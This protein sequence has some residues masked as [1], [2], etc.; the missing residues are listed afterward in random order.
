MRAFCSGRP[1]RGRPSFAWRRFARPCWRNRPARRSI[2][3]APKQATF[4]LE[5]QLLA[6]AALPGYIRLQILSFERLADFVLRTTGASPAGRSS[7]RTGGSM[8]LRALLARR[9]KELRIFHASAGLAGFA[10][11]LSLQLRELQRRRLSP[12]IC[13]PSPPKPALGESLR[14]KLHD[15]SLLLQDYLDWLRQHNLQDADSLLDLAADAL[16]NALRRESFHLG[17]LAGRFR[18][19]D[20]AGIGSAGRP[21]AA[22]PG[23]DAGLLPGGRALRPRKPPGF[24]SGRGI[25][26]TFQ[27]CRARLSALPGGALHRRGPGPPQAASGASPGIPF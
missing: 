24:P 12:D 4:Q 13:A 1:G 25:G 3:L 15:L 7:P 2:L 9:R 16:R 17:P 19:D 23:I 18:G 11:Q 22:L 8:V 27:Q 14:R 20:A 21:G 26:K 6:D 10:R 5:R